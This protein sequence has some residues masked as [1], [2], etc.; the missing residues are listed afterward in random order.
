MI[1]KYDFELLPTF[2]ITRGRVIDPA[3]NIDMMTDI[4]I[5]DGVIASLGTEPRNFIPSKEID[6]TGC[7]VCPGFVD[8]SVSLREPGYTQKGTIASETRAAASAGISTLCCPP[9]THP[10]LDT[11][12]VARLIQDIALESQMSKVLPIGAMT[13]GLEGKQLSAMFGLTQAGCTAVT[14][15]RHTIQSTRVLRHCYE[16]AAT[17][18]ILVFIQ[19]ED[20]DLAMHGVMHE[21]ETS[22]RL[23]LTGI[24]ETA[25][26]IAVAKSLLL[27]EQTGVRAH[28]NQ[29]STARSVELIELAQSKN[30]PVSA[31][32][33]I[34]HLHF[35]DEDVTGFNSM[36]H[37]YPPLRSQ[38]DRSQLRNALKT[39]AISCMSSHHQ[40]H[41]SAAKFAP[42]SASEPGISSLDT[43]LP[44][45]LSLV[46]EGVLDLPTLIQRMTSGPATVLEKHS[47]QSLERGSLH[48]GAAADICIFDPDKRWTVS[49]KTMISSGKNSPLL[50]RTLKGKTK[51]LIIDGIDVYDDTLTH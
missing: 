10:I 29:L 36:L 30:M 16:Y 17:H 46:D 31:D 5:V 21:G 6:A 51:Y 15:G 22:T 2:K 12:A 40:P 34:Q 44:M 50:G 23:G 19:A 39:G 28:F 37:T 26:T 47:N 4:Y 35:I 45:A 11:S 25:E 49:K 20:S 27:I 42:F 8:L 13:Q 43:Y 41:D 9:D 38:L 1:K 48:V 32:V 18:D 14:N 24:P 7:I 3:N 33:S